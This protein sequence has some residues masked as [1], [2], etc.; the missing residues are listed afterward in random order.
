[1]FSISNQ[2][3]FSSLSESS[4]IIQCTSY[5]HIRS[6]YPRI[7][8]PALYGASALIFPKS[9]T[10]RSARFLI[11]ASSSLLF[12]LVG[13]VLR[14]N[15]PRAGRAAIS[16]FS[17]TVT[18]EGSAVAWTL[19]TAAAAAVRA[20]RRVERWEMRPVPP[21]EDL[22]R[23]LPEAAAAAAAFRSRNKLVGSPVLTYHPPS[24][25]SSSESEAGMMLES[26]RCGEGGRG[27][28]AGEDG[29]GRAM[30]SEVLGMLEPRR[31]RVAA[32]VLLVLSAVARLCA[33]CFNDTG[34]T[35]LSEDSTPVDLDRTGSYT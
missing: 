35:G 18:P 29:F 25:G 4:Y 1:M 6:N 5:N 11:A 28:G 20:C 34:E 2:P 19:L 33:G 14:L 7:R 17:M 13:A 12:R 30:S 15:N 26:A 31:R 10:A 23:V 24:G 21:M 9:L 22:R 32:P 16:G 8:E 27:G 3:S